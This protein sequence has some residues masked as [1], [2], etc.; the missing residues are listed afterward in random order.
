MLLYGASGF[1]AASAELAGKPVVVGRSADLRLDDDTIEK[2]HARF[3][4]RDGK[5]FVAPIGRAAILLGADPVSKETEVPPG[6]I[7]LLARSAVVFVAA[8]PQQKPSQQARKVIKEIVYY[9]RDR[10]L[11]RLLELHAPPLV[12]LALD[13]VRFLPALR[14]HAVAHALRPILGAL[15][16]RPDAPPSEQIAAIE[17]C[18]AAEKPISPVLAEREARER[19]EAAAAALPP[20]PPLDED[21]DPELSSAPGVLTRAWHLAPSKEDVGHG[22]SH[23]APPID[24]SRWP[25]SPRDGAPMTHLG[26][27]L[28]PAEYRTAGPDKV[29]ISV[30]QA[31]DHVRPRADAPPSGESDATLLEDE[32]GGSYAVQWLDGETFARGPGRDAPEGAH[33]K[34]PQFLRL[35]ARLG[36]PNVGKV[37]PDWDKPPGDYVRPDSKKGEELALARFDFPNSRVRAHFGGTS[38]AVDNFAGSLGPFYLALE[39]DFGGANFGGGNAVLD[40]ARMCIVFGS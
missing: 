27:M 11:V 29:A 18:L 21:A 20:P 1:R 5:V 39:D 32:I 12:L 9:Q 35:R 17:A 4:L 13:A 36:D 34:P 30:F 25:R 14:L 28:V 40:L 37:I 22:F 23:G 8:D 38:F 19:R 33:A 16:E 6:D 3:T 2:K 24:P 10:L 26:T 15:A 7:V 31:D